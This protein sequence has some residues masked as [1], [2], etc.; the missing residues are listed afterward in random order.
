MSY[1]FVIEQDNIGKMVSYYRNYL[2]NT[3]DSRI[4]YSFKSPDFKIIIY[5]TRKVLFQGKNNFEEYEKWAK[6]FGVEV[7]PPVDYSSYTNQYASQ[8]IIGSDEVGTGD[9]FGPVVVCAAYVSPKDLELI[10][11][12]KV[13]DSKALSD[14]QII[15]LAKQ[16]IEVFSYHVLVLPN[17]KYNALV[18]QGYNMNKIKAYLHNHAIKKMV[19]KHPDY[20]NIIIDEFCS[21]EN[22]YK[23]LD[24]EKISNTKFHTKGESV[25]P[26]VA[27]ASII[28]RYKFLLEMDKLSEEIHITLPKGAG[29][30]VDAVG[31]V[32]YL[33]NGTAI[34]N[35]I[36]KTH[37]KN[38]DRITK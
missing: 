6:I 36:A 4:L 25:H 20:Q 10:Q 2:E 27:V 15:A 8:R 24:G 32:I 34:F 23:Y 21:P 12:L 1:D 11:E 16:L 19:I 14:Q 33:K 13:K 26:A 35:K 18:A 3:A 37:F 28:A 5:N 29:A 30:P 31:K 22:F 7:T 17:E 9:F 38:F